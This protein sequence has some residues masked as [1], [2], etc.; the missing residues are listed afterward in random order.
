[1]PRVLS[2]ASNGLTDTWG[3][4][5]RQL[6][7]KTCVNCGASFRPKR[8]AS[9]YCSRPCLWSNNGGQNKKPESWWISTDG[10]IDGEV[11][12]GEQKRRVKYHRIIMER[13]IGRVLLPSEDVHHIN[14][15][16]TD[17]R[18][19]NLQVIDHG[20]HASISNAARAALEPGK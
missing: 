18:I 11:W 14:G 19:E 15:C 3:R 7:D 12:V 2:P 10:Y 4:R 6:A 1:M 16:K 20:E 5:N 8:A 9:K 13:H 17:N